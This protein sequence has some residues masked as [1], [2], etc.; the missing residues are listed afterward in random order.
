MK[1]DPVS[2][3]S[4]Y[5]TGRLKIEF[6]YPQFLITESQN[7]AIAK[8]FITK[9]LYMEGSQSSSELHMKLNL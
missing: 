6:P 1:E 9:N 7:Q 8:T 4:P 2:Q 3:I 5:K